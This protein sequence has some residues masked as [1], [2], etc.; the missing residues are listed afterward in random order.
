MCGREQ[1]GYREI[2]CL[3]AKVAPLVCLTAVLGPLAYPAAALGGPLAW[4]T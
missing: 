1:V 3:A 2:A 4:L